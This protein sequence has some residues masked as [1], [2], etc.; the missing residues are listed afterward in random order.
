MLGLSALV[1]NRLGTY[2]AGAAAVTN[3]AVASVAAGAG[4]AGRTRSS[5]V[6]LAAG[7]DAPVRSCDCLLYGVS[8]RQAGGLGA[9]I[10]KG[11]MCMLRSSGL[12]RRPTTMPVVFA[13][14]AA[15]CVFAVGAAAAQAS[16][17]TRHGAR[18]SHRAGHR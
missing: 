13:M 10:R 14:S 6:D 17:V 12:S 5:S 2:V 4:G 11:G 1:S 15:L 3:P 16:H 18:R 7:V 9:C 8:C